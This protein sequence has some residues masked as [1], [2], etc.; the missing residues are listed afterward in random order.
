MTAAHVSKDARQIQT[1]FGRIAPVYDRLNHAFSLSIDRAWRRFAVNEALR[2]SDRHVLDVACGTGDLAIALRSAAHGDCQVLG[3]D[4]CHPM[5]AIARNKSPVP[6]LQADG[7]RL[8][9]PSASFDLV[10]IGFGLRNMESTEAGLR[11][12]GRVLK[13]GGRLCVLEFATPRNPVFR[14]GYLAYFKGILPAV[15]NFVSR[16]GAYGYLSRSVL[17]WPSPL[18]LAR[19]MKRCGFARVRHAELSFGIAFVH[20]AERGKG[21]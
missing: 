21:D 10:T 15:G 7:L 2:P 9:F 12:M 8:P 11:E 13:P 16:S 1:M 4:F 17:E 20:I 5:L 14:A 3:A 18:E 6:F 19:M